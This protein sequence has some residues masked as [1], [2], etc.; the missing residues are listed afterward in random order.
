MNFLKHSFIYFLVALIIAATGG[1]SILQQGCMCDGGKGN[2]MLAAA[3]EMNGVCANACCGTGNSETTNNC[4]N[5]EHGS[6]GGKQSN[7]SADACCYVIY[8]FFK[9][10]PANPVDPIQTSSNSPISSMV[11]LS[12][13]NA[14]TESELDL[15][16]VHFD[17]SLPSRFGK[18]LLTFLHMLKTGPLLG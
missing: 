17:P 14:G 8:S 9:T 4:C 16:Q 5:S 3:V 7:P 11:I 6:Q 2:M 1:I 13:D 15:H 10:D 12:D 18:E